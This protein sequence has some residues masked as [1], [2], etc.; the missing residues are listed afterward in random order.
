[1]I[2]I[3]MSTGKKITSILY[4]LDYYNRD[5][6]YKEKYYSF[7]SQAKIANAN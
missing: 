6:I 2:C 5:Y 7:F 3:I 1:M 4:S